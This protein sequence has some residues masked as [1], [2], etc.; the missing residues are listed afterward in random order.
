MS[1]SEESRKAELVKKLAL[2]DRLDAMDRADDEND[3]PLPVYAPM[4]ALEDTARAAGQG[5]TLG[6]LPQVQ[7]ALESGHVSGPEY[8]A[9][10]TA[11]R[12][13]LAQAHRRNPQLTFAG[14]ALSSALPLPGAAMATGAKVG[15]AVRS[16]LVN[17]ILGAAQN[18]GGDIDEPG[19]L[20]KR[21]WGAGIGGTVGA[22]LGKLQT[23]S[24]P[25]AEREAFR[26]L[27][28]T[29][30]DVVTARRKGNINS[31]GRTLLDEGVI[32]NVPRSKE[33][34]YQRALEAADDLGSQKS[35][36][37]NILDEEAGPMGFL[38]KEDIGNTVKNSV[39]LNEQHPLAAARAER[40]E[41]FASG[42][43]RNSPDGPFISL[44]EADK[45]K[46]DTGKMINWKKPPVDFTEKEKLNAA[47]YHALNEGVDAKA[48]FIVD[49][50][51]LANPYLKGELQRTKIGYGNVD[52]SKRI[53]N[54]RIAAEEARRA[55]SPSDYGVGLSGIMASL[56]GGAE[57]GP[58]VAIGV[59]LGI[60]NKLS[61]MYGRQLTAKQLDNISRVLNYSPIYEGMMSAPEGI[62][63]T[64]NRSQSP[65]MSSWG[66]L[67]T[68]KE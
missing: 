60:T 54:D 10:K 61:R 32:G 65:Q 36:V 19:A 33:T 63:G 24:G 66:L 37:I 34:L 7:A 48:D 20:K 68:T 17:A 4:Q 31:I 40:A 41:R 18:P 16:A 14:E 64:Y 42:I 11:S 28:P 67:R 3:A 21:L 30:R 49:K 43:A 46:T 5:L 39:A 13:A 8:E 45:L 1:Q 26:A 29:K 55:I 12:A 6:H 57:A 59:G 44:R 47:L 25:A 53:L 15:G 27:G 2:M 51:V 35:E 22:L 50:T 56:V 9:A 58:A 52:T 38:G 23:A 62:Y